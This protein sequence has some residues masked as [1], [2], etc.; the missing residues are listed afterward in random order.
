M[1]KRVRSCL[2]VVSA[3]ILFVQAA[4]A[5]QTAS[6]EGRVMDAAENFAL[7]GTNVILF[8]GDSDEQVMGAATDRD[9]RYSLAGIAPGQ[10]TLAFSFIGY[11]EERIPLSLEAGAVQMINVELAPVGLNL[12]AVIV[13]ASRQAEKVLDA[14]ASV[15]VLDIEEIESNVVPSSAAVLRNT[16][17]VD[18]AQTGIDRYE[19][20]LR[21]FNNAFSGA[22]YVLNDYRQGAIASLGVNAYQMMPITQID[23][24]R[25][26]VVRGPGSALY[27]A[28]VDA[29]VVH[30]ITK[31][32]FTYP[33]TTLSIGGGERNLLMG[34]LRHAGVVNERIGYKVVGNF[35]RADEWRYDCDYLGDDAG[36]EPDDYLRCGDDHDFVQVGGFR[37]SALPIDYENWKYNLSGML[38][39]RLSPTTT[40]TANGGFSSSN[41]IFLSGIGTLQAGGFGYTYGQLRLRS[42]SFFA[43]AYVNANNAGDSFVYRDTAVDEVVDNSILFNAQTQYDFS[44]AA[45]RLRLIVGADFEHTAPDTEGTITGRNEED[46]TIIEA[47]TYAQGTAVISPKLDGTVA[48]RAD[49]NNVAEEVQLS[50]RAAIV[51]KVTPSHSLRATYNRAFSSPGTNSLFLDINAGSAGPLT[52]RARG[53][54]EGYTFQRR[55]DGDLIASS[56]IPDMFGGDMAVGMPLGFVYGQVYETIAA[57]P[58]DQLQALLQQQG[59]DLTLEQVA[60]LVA[61]LSPEAGTNVTGV[62]ESDLGFLNLT[63]LM[64]DRRADDVIDIA[65]LKPTVSQTFELGYKGLFND[66]LLFAVDAYYVKKRNFVGP[67]LVESPFVRAPNQMDVINDLRTA[68]AGGIAGNDPLLAQLD[69]LGIPPEMVAAL[70]TSLASEGLQSTL[71]VEGSPIGIVQPRE[72]AIPGQL[73][74]T[75]R[76]FGEVEY[77][78][79][80]ISSQFAVSDQLSIFGNLSW[81]DDNFFDSDELGEEVATLELAMNAP[82]WKVKA[83]FDYSVPEGVRFGAALRHINGFRVR[84]GPYEGD[85]PDYTLLDVNAGY[86]LNALT[87]GLRFDLTILNLL[88]NG[89]REFIGAPR[90]GRLAMARLT[91]TM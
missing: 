46:D 54:H 31:D 80:D 91:Y 6:V 41:S 2:I 39:Y 43:Q 5:Q 3:L 21:G 10:Y 34:S 70:I 90:L 1:R 76:N 33:G 66:R 19:I 47:G 73:L 78:G 15:S 40:L 88:D 27:G 69:Q 45:D 53:A 50:P 7:V 79:I 38:A 26:E 30:F 25:V 65:P 58:T 81:V 63:T 13:T 74:L 68:I 62:S 35:T 77:F 42:G 14:P 84:S 75:Y 67:L 12:N 16:T 20:V 59:L 22:T 56:L 83:G 82:D 32:P 18:M 64:V 36:P 55:P 24:E 52:I 60:G 72:N 51:Y 87:S 89:H 11:Q 49:Y 44:L 17:G 9:G 86:D 85:V 57:I 61:L 28:G 23:L 48:L 29:G 8:A 4:A 37:R 71:P